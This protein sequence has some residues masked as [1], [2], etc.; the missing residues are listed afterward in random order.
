MVTRGLSVFTLTARYTAL[1][2]LE[3]H[4][5]TASKCQK[6]LQSQLGG[7]MALVGP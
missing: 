6:A 3:S 2:R 5:F 1:S 7:M 4:H